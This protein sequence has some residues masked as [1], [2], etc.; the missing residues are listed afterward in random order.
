MVK[1]IKQDVVRNINAQKAYIIFWDVVFG[2]IINVSA[3]VFIK[4]SLKG[5]GIWYSL[6]FGTLGAWLFFM[7][8]IIGLSIHE[9][10]RLNGELEDIKRRVNNNI[11]GDKF[12]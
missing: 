5:S 1:S 10:K 9:I 12:D 11:K 8:L 3:I 7:I 2:I 6:F 4:I